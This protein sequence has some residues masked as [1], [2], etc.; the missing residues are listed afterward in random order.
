MRRRK[1]NALVAF[2]DLDETPDMD[3]RH[4]TDLSVILEYVDGDGAATTR[5]VRIIRYYDD[6]KP[7]LWCWCALRDDARSF[8]VERIEGVID[9]DGV[10]ETAEKFLSR[11]GIDVDA[12]GAA[13]P[14]PDPVPAPAPAVK[15]TKP[16]ETKAG[17]VSAATLA[18]VAESN[19]RTAAAA[20]KPGAASR[21]RKPLIGLIVVAALLA[22]ALA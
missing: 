22:L 11:F 19:R 17:R 7:L 9:A 8:L 13:P 21:W 14:A 2:A 3:E 4:L 1:N 15:R 16:S 18:Y 6:R 5:Q 20:A 10:V 12:G